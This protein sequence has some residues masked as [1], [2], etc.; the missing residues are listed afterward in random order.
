MPHVGVERLAAGDHQHDRREHRHTVPALPEEELHRV[1]RIDRVEHLGLHRDTAN[2]EECDADEPEGGHR[3][4]D[5]ADTSGAATLHREE[6]RDDHHRERHDPRLEDRR[7]D[8]EALDGAEH[9]DGGSD[10]AVA[11]E[12][13]RAEE[14]DD[15]DQSAAAFL[16]AGAHQGEERENAALTAIVGPH[17][18]P[19]VL[20]RDDEVERPEDQREDSQHIVVGERDGVEPL[21]RLLQRVERRRTDVAVNHSECGEGKATNG[22]A[23]F[24]A[25]LFGHGTGAGAWVAAAFA[26]ISE[27]TSRT[28]PSALSEV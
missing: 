8:F 13:C 22:L 16:A 19:D 28:M 23:R 27:S 10:H 5:L 3:T 24:P 18:E 9:G 7:G 15:Q 4:E 1:P 25:M 2:A 17:H 20:E 21:K 14:P 11:V 26:A 12:Q 6:C